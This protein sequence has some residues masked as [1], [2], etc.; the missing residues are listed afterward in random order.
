QFNKAFNG[1]GYKAVSVHS[2]SEI[3]RN[4]ALTMLGK[5]EIQILFSVDL[6]NEGTDLPSIDTIL[7][8]RPTQSNIIFLQ[9]LGRGLRTSP[10]KSHV[11][12]LDFLGNHK[13][14]LSRNDLLQIPLTGTNNN[15][16]GE[17]KGHYGSLTELGEGCHIN[18]DPEVINFWTELKKRFK[19]T[20]REEFE[21]LEA[22]LGHRP[23]ATEFF[24]HGYDLKKVNKQHGSWLEFVSLYSDSKELKS[25]VSRWKTFFLT[26]IQETSRQK[27]YKPI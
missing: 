17:E 1:K 23:T 9:Q 20:A 15:A 5:G 24:H 27:S 18:I 12:V 13:S 4:E 6:F 22:R 16:I 8:I 14:F 11:V 10:N 25:L 19:N 26:D 7:M 3:R 21:M 2:Q